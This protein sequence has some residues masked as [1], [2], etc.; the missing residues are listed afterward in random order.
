[1][2]LISKKQYYFILKWDISLYNFSDHI[3]NYTNDFC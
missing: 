1:M 2:I 3:L